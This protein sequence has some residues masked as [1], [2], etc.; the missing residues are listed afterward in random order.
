[1]FFCCQLQEPK[2]IKDEFI[3]ISTVAMY[4]V[5]KTE[6]SVGHNHGTK[7]RSKSPMKIEPMISSTPVRCS[8]TELHNVP[9]DSWGARSY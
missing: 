8:T 2:I 1:M 6:Y 3:I 4:D 7:K 9:G 5:R